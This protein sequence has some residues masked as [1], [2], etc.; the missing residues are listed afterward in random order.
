[1]M[2]N[3]TF[4]ICAYK[5]SPFL[6]ECIESVLSQD[7]ADSE[8]Y[9]STSTPND[10]ICGLAKKYGLDVYVNTGEHGIGPDWNYAY[11][12]AK[13]NYI[14]IAHQDDVYLP[15][16]AK[17]AID[18]LSSRS[19][20]LIFFSNY[21]EIRN[22]QPVDENRNLKIKRQLLKRLDGKN[23]DN[24]RARRHA[25]SFGN[26]ICCPAVT[27]NKTNCPNPPFLT[28]MK[29]NIDWGTWERL[30]LLEGGFCYDPDI[31]MRHR[32]HEESTTSSLIG[33]N[34]RYN[35]DFEMLER[36]WPTP[37]A[38]LI[39]HFYKQSENSNAL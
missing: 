24:I 30:S 17:A 39:N 4:A 1:M 18:S 12:R 2:S 3:H 21:G 37:I 16:Y 34:T 26:P 14:T 38:K 35:E 5:E 28:D 33:D 32:I 15:G 20:S 7:N 36:F 27:F 31:L 19:D 29:S 6:G 9:I 23:V 13:G 10:Y 22:G 25:L 8:V 11:S